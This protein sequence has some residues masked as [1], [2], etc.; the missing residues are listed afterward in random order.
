[1][2]GVKKTYLYHYVMSMAALVVIITGIK[3]GS[4]IVVPLLLS[5][6]LALLAHPIV[7]MCVRRKIPRAVGIMLTLTL[8]VVLLIFVLASVVDTLQEFIVAFPSYRQELMDSWNKLREFLELRNI[9]LDLDSV[10]EPFDTSVVMGFLT[11]LASRLGGI[12]SFTFLVVL[13][14]IFMLLEAPLIPSKLRAALSAPDH[15]LRAVQRFLQAFNRYVALKTLISMIT[16]LM[17]GTMLW[18]IGV[19]FYLLWGLVAFLFN[20][21]PNVGSFLAAVP[22]I[23]VALLQLGYPDAILVTAGYLIINILIGNVVE[24]GVMGQGLGLSP[25]VVFLSLLI[26]GW[27]IGPVGMILSVPLTMFVKILMESSQRWKHAAV[28]LGP[29]VDKEPRRAKK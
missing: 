27:M 12:M 7:E 1:M 24:P 2:M 8:F 29:G 17:V 19:Q 13:S 15:E 23:L 16:G 5:S 26:W 4:E 25:L 9:P 22:G 10:S 18:A 20:Y 21:I 6:M 11:N 14:S 3:L 28:L